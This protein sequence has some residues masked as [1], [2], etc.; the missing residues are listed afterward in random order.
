M[1]GGIFHL[2]LGAR[3]TFVLGIQTHCLNGPS[4][5]GSSLAHPRRE[6]SLIRGA[7]LYPSSYLLQQPIMLN[8]VEVGFVIKIDDSCLPFQDRFVHM[9]YR[10]LSAPLRLFD[11]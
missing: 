11:S 8:A 10:F 9:E 3:R 6:G 2:R 1:S 5:W 4:R 7:I